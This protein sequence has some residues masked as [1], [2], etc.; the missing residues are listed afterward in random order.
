VQLLKLT[1]PLGGDR[2]ALTREHFGH[3]LNRLPLRHV[4][5]RLMQAVLYHQLGD[6]RLAPNGLQRH[7]RL[8]LRGI[9][10]RFPATQTVLLNS[11]IKR[12][13]LPEFRG[14]P[15]TEEL[16]QQEIHGA[17][18]NPRIVAY[19]QATGLRANDDEPP[20]CGSFVAWCLR[21]AGILYDTAR[22]A[23]ARSWLSWG[24]TLDKPTIGCIVVFWRG[25]RDGW[26]VTSASTPAARRTATSSSSVATRAMASASAV[27]GGPSPQVG[28]YAADVFALEDHSRKDRPTSIPDALLTSER[29][30]LT[31]HIGSAV[32]EVREAIERSAAESLVSVLSGHIP[33]TCVNAAA[34]TAVTGGACR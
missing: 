13:S 3:S 20:W 29:T 14:P 12:S 31:P 19:R 24:R 2:L 27:P 16:G 25:K 7:L 22:A 9:R 17:T 34:V 11:R 6:R 10:F 5:K 32:G 21:D 4:D 23:A 30:V 33:D 15:H 1:F 28:G 26:Q 8:E 18:H